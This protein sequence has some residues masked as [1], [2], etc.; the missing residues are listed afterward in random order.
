LFS[1]LIEI[2]IIL[3][4]ILNIFIA[5]KAKKLDLLIIATVFAALFENLHVFLFQNYTGGYYYSSE[6]LVSIYKVPL[7]V[8]LSWGIIIVDAYIIATKLTNNVARI[9]LVPILAVIADLALEFFAVQQGYWAWIGYGPMQGLFG[10]PASNFISWMLI[11]LALVFTYEQLKEK[12]AVPI[13]AYT[14]FVIMST[15]VYIISGLLNLDENQQVYIIWAMIILFSSVTLAL[16]AV[17]PKEEL[18]VKDVYPSVISTGFFFMFSILL[19]ITNP[20]VTAAI[21]PILVYVYLIE[22][23]VV[24]ASC[25]YKKR[26]IKFI[27][28]FSS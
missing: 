1:L 16:W 13:M 21:L 24:I 27:S 26:K 4:F 2:G 17:K 14:L 12:W 15:G 8:I 11:T 22:L 9:F 18:K 25:I 5:R 7:F 28:S 3:L 20:T 19:A 23:I 6:F 10:V